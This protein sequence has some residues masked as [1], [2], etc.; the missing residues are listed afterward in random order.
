[1]IKYIL[2]GVF[3]VA[4][5][6][7]ACAQTNV[8]SWEY[9]YDH[10]GIE[11]GLPSSETYQVF[12]D[13]TGF[14]WILTDRGVVRYDGFSFQRYTEENGL[15]DNVN[16]RMVEDADGGVW[17]VGY[18]GLLSVYRNGKIQPYKYND[19]LRKEIPVM[20]H[21]LVY[22][23][24]RKDHSIVYFAKKKE[25]IISVS[26]KG[27]VTN[28]L[29][30]AGRGLYLFEIEGEL[31]IHIKDYYSKPKECYLIRNGKKHLLSSETNVRAFSRTKRLGNHQFI[32]VDR[33]L[34][35]LLENGVRFFPEKNEV[36]GLDADQEFLYVGLYKNGMKKYRFDP[37][38]K[39]LTFVQHYLPDYSVSSAYKDRNGTLWM[40]TLEKGVF[41]IYDEAFRQL[42]VNHVRVQDEVRFIN[43][44]GKKIIIT[45]HIG[46]W[47][48][49]YAPYLLKDVG[50]LTQT[51]VFLPL[52]DKFLFQ[53]TETDWSGWKDIRASSFTVPIFATD[54]SVLGI[55]LLGSF[56]EEKTAKASF[57]YD[58][59]KAFVKAGFQHLPFNVYLSPERL[60][61]IP[62][63]NELDVFRMNDA[64]GTINCIRKLDLNGL[65]F[66]RSNPQW[67]VLLFSGNEGILHLDI[68]TFETRKITLKM[69][70][71]KQILGAFFD[72][73]SRLWLASEKG[74]FLLKKIRDE[75]R[76]CGFLNTSALSSAE[77]T[78]L[79]AYEG[80]V[81]L[82]TK[83]GVQK[84]DF[85]KRK[86]QHPGCPVKL[87]SIKAFD[88]NKPVNPGNVYPSTTDFIRI[89]LLN[90][91]LDKRNTF[92]YRFGKDQ[93]WI[94]SDK[95]EIT[96]NNPNNGRFDLEISYLDLFGHWT[97]PR[98]LTHFEVEKIIF[99]RWYF[100]LIYIGLLG[101]LF[102]VVL[103]YTVRMVN[104]KN[105]LLNRVAELER[106][107]LTA[108]M[109]PHFIFNSLNSI[110]SFLLYEENENA[111]KY[112]LRFAKLIRQTLVNSRV[113][114]ITV[115]EEVEALENYILLESMRFKNLFTYQITCDLRTLPI[116][117][118]IPPMLIQPYVENAILHG[119]VKRGSGGELVLRFYLEDDL[120]KVLIQ[121]NGVG[122]SGTKKKKHDANH[123][124]YGTKITEER[125]K[126][127][128]GKDKKAFTVSISNVDESNVEFPG[129]RII[130]TIPIPD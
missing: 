124:S 45:Y 8:V 72:E 57:I 100:I 35:V 4:I 105:H 79:Y 24:V 5:A 67:G 53:K 91:N 73:K 101:I 114:Y 84:I 58:T 99:L 61:F 85:F 86:N 1:M 102:Y 37:K 11:N 56:V 39:E 129:T 51:S 92:R 120:L 2:S 60:L 68:R 48:Q 28:L 115:E 117:P 14:L 82:T 27:K 16:F 6:M 22:L 93:T 41:A 98:M 126:S 21:P 113:S 111:E 15:A 54:T 25:K 17:F 130:L 75:V 74:V 106:M 44:I 64:K 66:L 32:I 94:R 30:G 119:L 23:H 19:L 90:E 12:Q 20:H 42:S 70:L 40:T 96:L 36:I 118:C 31:M 7:Q 29:K 43:G 69:S 18:N 13:K 77:I 108:Q 95:G 65:K 10:F 123:K 76:I 110:H 109:N 38:T 87:A 116:H 83:F 104:R 52:K 127:L 122:Y 80:I 63:F 33:K 9:N 59:K 62:N 81:Y 47:Q 55:D 46:K 71:G 103:K 88:N 125:L 49:L 26:S 112:L 97:K 121:D 50:K 128:Q 78:D 3:F 107:A 89:S 34:C